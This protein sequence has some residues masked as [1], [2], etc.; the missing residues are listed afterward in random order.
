M[1]IDGPKYLEYV[2]TTCEG[3]WMHST[4]SQGSRGVTGS[5]QPIWPKPRT[6]ISDIP[7]QTELIKQALQW[8][9]LAENNEFISVQRPL[10]ND[11]EPDA[12]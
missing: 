5:R 7:E 11:N 6:I 10:A 3:R 4:S 8:I 2:R 9:A 12:Q 1:P